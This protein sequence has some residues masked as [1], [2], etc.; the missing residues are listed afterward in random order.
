MRHSGLL[1]PERVAAAVLGAV[2]AP[3]GMHMTEIEVDPEAPV[4]D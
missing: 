2:K 3:R 4:E 1:T